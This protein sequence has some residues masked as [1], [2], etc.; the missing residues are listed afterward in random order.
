MMRPAI[1]VGGD[2]T[3]LSVARNLSRAGI[4]VYLLNR[5]NVSAR[6]SRWG[7]WITVP[8]GSDT[9]QDWRRFL[10]GSDSDRLAGAVLLACSDEA[11]AM[12]SENWGALSS[13]FVLEE[14][15]PQVR[16]QLL[17]K[18]STYEIARKGGIPVPGFWFAKSKADLRI[19]EE[20]CRFPVILKPRLSY[21]SARI[22]RKH[23]RANTSSELA[24][25]FSRLA[26]LQ[27]PAVIMEFIPGGDDRLCS[28][29]TY[30]D[31]DG[32]PLIQFT[33]RH[34]RRFPMNI[35]GATYH[36]TTWA[37]EVAALGEKFFRHA[38]LRGLGN[39]EFK[40]DDRDQKLKI[41]ESNARFT[42]ADTL[43]SR[44]GID[45]ARFAYDRLTGH[46]PPVPSGYRTGMV[47]WCPF[48]DFFAFLELRQKGLISLAEWLRSVR[49]TD[50]FQY[51][52]WNDPL[53][54]VVNFLR[55]VRSL[56][57]RRSQVMAIMD[58]RKRGDAN[59][60]GRPALSGR[61][62]ASAR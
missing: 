2:A 26:A 57:R 52:Q 35:G 18:L 12:M 15:P 46:S 28:Y 56:P 6:Y 1:I 29:Y 5:P 51:W 9:Q 40:F 8:G 23:L 42:D 54:S 7:R 16:L 44:S 32:T 45:F 58:A 24:T 50:V 31:V 19:V 27:I 47:L 41:I 62:G 61:D 10:L 36:E 48:Q 43:I 22:G 13:K 49:R 30:M 4:P 14:S 3:A 55:L 59:D 60:A 17:D 25:E 11:I 20:E 34:P 53:P 38:G 37:P 33:K 39:V 21:D